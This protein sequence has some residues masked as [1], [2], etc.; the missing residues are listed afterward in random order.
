MDGKR[1]NIEN[2]PFVFSFKMISDGGECFAKETYVSH[3]GLTVA[4]F[5]VMRREKGHVTS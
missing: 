2:Q 5:N 1:L 4:H 3:W